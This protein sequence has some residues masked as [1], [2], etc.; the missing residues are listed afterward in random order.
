M[1]ALLGGGGG[2][3]FDNHYYYL[4]S[5]LLCRLVSFIEIANEK[6]NGT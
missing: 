3:T 1:K 6:S 2:G 5:I 4:V